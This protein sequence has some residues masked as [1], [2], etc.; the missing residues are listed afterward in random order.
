M[1]TVQL[2]M[3]RE[4]V[5]E[6]PIEPL[7]IIEKNKWGL[8]TYSELAEIHGVTVLDVINTFQSE[9]GYTIV[10]NEGYTIAYNDTIPIKARIR[11]T[12][13]HE[14]G[15]IYLNHL[16][17]FDETILRRSTLTEAQYKVLEQEVNCFAR[18]VLAPAPIIKKL[19]LNTEQD[20]MH[21]FKISYRA[22]SVR[23]QCLKWDLTTSLNSLLFQTKD[24]LFRAL[25]EKSCPQCK[26]YFVLASAKYCPNCGNDKLLRRKVNDVMIYDK[27]DL[28]EAGRVKV[29]PVCQNEEIDGD[30]NFCKIC[31]IGLINRCTRI[32]DW[33]TTEW[34]RDEPIHCDGEV[35][36]NSRY[37]PKCGE[38]T[39]YLENGLLIPWKEEYKNNKK[40]E[41]M[42]E[43]ERIEEEIEKE[44]EEEREE[45]EERR[46]DYMR[47][48]YSLED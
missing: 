20:L 30:S 7:E 2:F 4:E 1:K 42:L 23:L 19:G 45:E 18:N 36:G 44:L 24:F 11:F 5:S 25:N 46:R 26:H 22:A 27:Y 9:D 15:H 43:L 3:K 32:V 33:T 16:R 28:D 6:F 21:Y 38:G 37:C 17:E 14:I 40:A 31:G 10:D 13:M 41:F 47:I 34:N 48:N 29:C 12:L 39:T 8:I 35:T